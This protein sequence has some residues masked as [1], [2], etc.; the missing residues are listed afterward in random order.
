MTTFNLPLAPAGTD[1]QLAVWE[2]LQTFPYGE[3]WSYG[4]LA[5]KLG[6]SNA[7]RAVGAANG[8]DCLP[9]NGVLKLEAVELHSTDA[10]LQL[11]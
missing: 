9:V 1:F 3:T 7:S 6:R 5:H 11:I 10:Q 4:E 8:A 2:I